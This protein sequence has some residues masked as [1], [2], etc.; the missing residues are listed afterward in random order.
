[1]LT[2]KQKI[3]YIVIDGLDENWVE[4]KLRYKLIKGLV[5]TAR[6][7]IGIPNV[8]ILIALCRDLIDRVFFLTRDSGFQEEKYQGLY[9]PLVWNKKDILE[10]L[11]QRVCQLVRRRYTNKQVRY[12]DLLPQEY[13]GVAIEDFIFSVANRP[14]DVIAFFNTCIHAAID[15][16]RLT[17]REF[18]RAI[19]EYSRIRLGALADEWYA[20]YPNLLDFAEVLNGRQSSFKAD[21]IAHKDIEE[22]YL[23]IVVENPNGNGSLLKHASFLVENYGSHDDFRVT[24][25]R[26]FYR[27]GLVGLKTS[28]DMSASWVDDTGQS[29]SR[30]QIDENT[31]V[32]VA[33]KYAYALGVEAQQRSQALPDAIRC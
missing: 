12:T 33:P 4:E 25:L 17:K 2:D 28:T 29:V 8:K 14:R 26:V 32:V 9:L 23:E 10:V 1:M 24:L 18:T 30:G 19:G 5:L 20:E 16:T 15:K 22:L 21:N 7:F 11:D 27:V 6:E 3:Y 13:K 31:S